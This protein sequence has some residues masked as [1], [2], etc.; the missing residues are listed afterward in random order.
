MIAAH[1]R[2]VKCRQ[3]ADDRIVCLVQVPATM[4]I[5]TTS[6]VAI[7]VLGANIFPA[8]SL[9]RYLEAKVS[10]ARERQFGVSRPRS[11]LPESNRYWEY[12]IKVGTQTAQDRRLDAMTT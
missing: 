11:R 10:P 12:A 1:T 4:A 3:R 6:V 5:M 7:M 9:V 2:S 8:T